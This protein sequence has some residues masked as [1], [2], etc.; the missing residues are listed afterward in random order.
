MALLKKYFSVKLH[1]SSSES[2]GLKK[3][4]FSIKKNN[5]IH[6]VTYMC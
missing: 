1:N 3:F 6:C 5:N 4:Y 2:G